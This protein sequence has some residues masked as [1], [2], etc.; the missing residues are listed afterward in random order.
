MRKPLDESERIVEGGEDV[1]LCAL[2]RPVPAL[3][4]PDDRGQREQRAH[5][6]RIEPLAGTH[7]SSAVVR[8]GVERS[9]GVIARVLLVA[10]QHGETVS[11][12]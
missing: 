11:E 2:R 4:V 7:R 12:P 8:D 10:V 9:P 6:R 3:H 5:P 1:G